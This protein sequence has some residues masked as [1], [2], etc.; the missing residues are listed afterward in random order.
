VTLG[1]DNWTQIALGVLTLIG[2]CVAAWFGFKGQQA[3]KQAKVLSEPTGN[4]WTARLDKKLDGLIE[5]TART[6]VTAGL[7]LAMIR[8][9]VKDHALH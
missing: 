4:G 2:V 7:A 5:T 9:H 3:A 1:P 6:E 8:D